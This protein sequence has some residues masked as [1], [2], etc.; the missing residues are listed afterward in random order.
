MCQGSSGLL[1]ARSKF[2]LHLPPLQPCPHPAL[3]LLPILSSPQDEARSKFAAAEGDLVTS[4]NVWRAWLERGK[5][6]RW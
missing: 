2:D 3:P 1:G 6:H 4:L 5:D